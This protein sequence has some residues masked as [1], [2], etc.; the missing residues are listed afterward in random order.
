MSDFQ[1]V[2]LLG[3]TRRVVLLEEVCHWGGSLLSVSQ[4]LHQ[5]CTCLTAAIVP[6]VVVID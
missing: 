6:A 2:E 5:H 4:L 3:R 1:L